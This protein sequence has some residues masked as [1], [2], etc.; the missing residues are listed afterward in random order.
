MGLEACNGMCMFC[1][2]FGRPWDQQ[3]K[4]IMVSGS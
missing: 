2:F 4:E 1:M 3:R